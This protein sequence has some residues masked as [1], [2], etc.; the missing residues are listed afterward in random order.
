MIIGV[1]DI[2]RRWDSTIFLM[3]VS[4]QVCSCCSIFR[5]YPFT[6]RILFDTFPAHSLGLAFI[7][8]VYHI[9]LALLLLC[10]R[11]PIFIYPIIIVILQILWPATSDHRRGFQFRCPCLGSRCIIFSWLL[12]FISLATEGLRH[13]WQVVSATTSTPHP[14]PTPTPWRLL[15]RYNP[16]T[17]DLD[18]DHLSSGVSQTVETRMFFAGL[19]YFSPRV[20]YPHDSFQ[21]SV[22][23]SCDPT[24]RGVVTVWQIGFLLCDNWTRRLNSGLEFSIILKYTLWLTS[25]IRSI[26]LATNLFIK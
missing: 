6:R 19:N 13:W 25:P 8:A 9:T 16:L 22:F 4:S 11:V 17:S 3:R 15:C 7:S 1:T 12:R 14:T 23:F 24:V 26:W 5:M 21:A 18:P 20:Q 10:Y 2:S